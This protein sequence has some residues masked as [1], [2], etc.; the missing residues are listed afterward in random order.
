MTKTPVD[1]Q[2]LRRRIYVK[3]KAEPS[4]RF[5]GLYVH[6]CKTET[7]YEAF[8]LAKKNNGAPGID[9]ATFEAIEASGVEQFVEQLRRELSERTY[10]PLRVRKVGIPKDGGKVRVLSIPAIRDRVVQGALKLI[11]EPIFEADFQPGSYGYRP[12][13]SPQGAIQRVSDAIIQG[14][15]HVIDLDLRSYFDTVRHHIV[16]EKVAKRVK[17]D[18]VM[19]LLKMI[20][21]ASGKRGVPQGGVIS[22]LLS[23]LYL[24]EVDKMLERAREVTRYGRWTAVEYARFADDLV[25]LVDSHPRHRWLREAVERRLREELAKLQV[26]VN[27]EK[28]RR[29]DLTRGGS[30]GFLGFE[31]RRV[32]SRAGRWMPLRTPLLKKRTALLRELKMWFRRY[33]SQPTQALVTR[34]NAILRGWVNYFSFGHSSRCL[35]FIRNWVE[36]K[37]RR[38]LARAQLRRGFGWKRWSRRWMYEALGLF[39]DY[40][41]RH[42]VLSPKV[43]PAGRSH[44][45]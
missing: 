8:R 6:A 20:L 7:L 17:D 21:R 3:A 28:S 36:Q 25:I 31:F 42:L 12:K 13:R 29:V 35:S 4:W 34:I 37:I 2:D 11:L 33:R 30:F 27:E 19:H 18:D 38:H 45:P 1:L 44:N 39:N 32:R 26:E 5:W 24:N 16:L 40:R 43:A 10:R 41:V 22:P 14:K 9:G 15:T 23:N